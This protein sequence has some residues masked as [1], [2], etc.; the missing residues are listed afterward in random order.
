M[1]KL[2]M[3]KTIDATHGRK[4]HGHTFKIEI[5]LK[6]KLINNMVGNIDFHEIS[7]KIDRVIN[8]LDKSYIDDV[9]KTRATVENIAIYIINEL[10]D[11]KNLYS[12]VVWEG[13]DKY[14]E[15]LKDE[16]I[17]VECENNA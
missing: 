2:C 12:V 1:A 3:I 17:D 9:I 8:N 15:I 11:I 6:D 16:V 4:I 10:K 14:A 7:P 5:K 13:Q